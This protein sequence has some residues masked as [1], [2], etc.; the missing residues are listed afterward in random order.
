[1]WMRNKLNCYSYEIS[2]IMV[3]SFLAIFSQLFLS[4]LCYQK[5]FV[6]DKNLNWGWQRKETKTAQFS[7]ASKDVD[8]H[9]LEIIKK[10]RHFEKRLEVLLKRE[11]NWICETRLRCA[12]AWRTCNLIEMFSIRN[13]LESLLA[14]EARF[15]CFQVENDWNF[16]LS[17]T[18]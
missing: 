11:L 9:I 18:F 7:F 17:K 5:K 13:A 3:F 14:Y 12:E 8:T 16:S 2:L 15:S 6:A 4:Q 10:K 1:M